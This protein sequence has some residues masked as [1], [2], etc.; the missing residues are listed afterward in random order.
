MSSMDCARTSREVRGS[1]LA[2][3]GAGYV[4]GHVPRY[5]LAAFA[6][7]L[8]LLSVHSPARQDGGTFAP[9]KSPTRPGSGA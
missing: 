2:P 6:A 1:S 8:V 4:A 9:D 5:A 3:C 7:R